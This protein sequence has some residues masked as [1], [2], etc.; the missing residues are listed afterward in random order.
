M[1]GVDPATGEKSRRS[2][3]AVQEVLRRSRAAKVLAPS[4]RLHGAFFAEAKR[5]EDVFFGQNC[6]VE[7]SGEVEIQVGDTATVQ[8]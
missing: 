1:P 5:C 8:W 6:L 3:A 7:L 2:G 4:A